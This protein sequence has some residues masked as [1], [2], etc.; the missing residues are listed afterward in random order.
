MAKR[1]K[2]TGGVLKKVWGTVVNGVSFVWNQTIIYNIIL[3]VGVFLLAQWLLSYA[4]VEYSNCKYLI[5]DSLSM[6]DFMCDGVNLLAVTVPGLSLPM[7]GPLEWVRW[8]GVL[9]IIF[10][11][12]VISGYTTFILNNL[13]K[14]VRLVTFNSQ[15]WRALLSTM[16][17]FVTILFLL[18]LF[19]FI[20][21]Q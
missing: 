5:Q 3:G 9:A 18:L 17:T 15:E 6:P 20:W 2:T 21:I 10:F 16:R 19:F 14:V 13:K 11:G 1:K 12:I 8:G 7:D 4:F